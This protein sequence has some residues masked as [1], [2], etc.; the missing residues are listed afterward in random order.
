VDNFCNDCVIVAAC[1]VATGRNLELMNSL[2][3]YAMPA[4][5]VYLSGQVFT[6]L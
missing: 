3:S 2:V 6:L 1:L 5:L 4:N